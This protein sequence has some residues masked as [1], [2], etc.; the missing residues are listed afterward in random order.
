MKKTLELTNP[1]L[2]NGTKVKE[3][4]YDVDEITGVL[5]AEADAH[6]MSDSGTKS[7]NLAGAPEIDY[8]MHL[9]LGYAAIIAVNP[10]YDWEDLKRI[11]GHDNIMVLRIGRSF[12]TGSA[13]SQDENSDELTEITEESSTLQ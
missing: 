9:Y 6:K 7:G 4:T 12:I 5:F 8:S 11:K 1:I 2:I 13:A 10:S 3:L